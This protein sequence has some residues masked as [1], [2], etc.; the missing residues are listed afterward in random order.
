MGA[1]AFMST[2]KILSLILVLLVLTLIAFALRTTISWGHE[3]SLLITPTPTL[4]PTSPSTP[5][6]PAPLPFPPTPLP[7]MEAAPDA[8]LLPTAPPTSTY[9]ILSMSTPP[10]PTVEPT[11]R[12]RAAKRRRTSLRPS[13]TA[14]PPRTLDPRLP[15]QVFIR[16]A[17]VAAGQPYW[18]LVS[19]RW[20][21]PEE[22]GGRHHI[23][24]EVLDEH[25]H[26]LGGRSVRI[27]WPGGS[28][29]AYTDAAKPWGEAVSFPQ[30]GLLGSY[31]VAV[32][33]LP[34]DEIGGLGLGL[35]GNDGWADHTCWYLVF[36][37][38]KKTP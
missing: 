15:P 29:L 8:V 30:Y 12:H 23:F 38:S 33:G 26:R 3:G 16:E 37:R 24:V 5:T 32:L 22:A 11:A 21:P 4:V 7:E 10:P 17:E 1:V 19:V 2:V 9:I 35:P 20:L 34:G 14:T 28:V 18:R 27:S 36:Q 31:T 25:G 13:A 6:L